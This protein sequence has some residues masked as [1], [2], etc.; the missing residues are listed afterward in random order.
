MAD[1]N[2]RNMA[3]SLKVLTEARNFLT[4]FEAAQMYYK[5]CFD[6]Q[7]KSSRKCRS[8]VKNARLYISHFI[9][10]LNLSII[11]LEIKQEHKSLYGLPLSNYN[12]PD[13]IS[14]SAVLEWGERIITGEKDRLK[15]GGI[16]IYNPTIAKVSVHF[17]IFKETHQRQKDYQRITERS[18]KSLA[19]MRAEAD[20]II[21]DIWNQVEAF[22]DNL[23]AEDKM[24]KAID[25]GIIYYYRANEKAKISV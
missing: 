11:R 18:L 24:K 6:N 23:P 8:A 9:Q 10:V 22:Y 20:A 1:L 25:Y 17:D 21:L 7:V 15:K 13:L 16:P 2:I 3:F 5:Q 12:V 19:S 4:R 14:D